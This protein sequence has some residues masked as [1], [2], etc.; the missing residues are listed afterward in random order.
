MSTRPNSIY[1]HQNNY[2]VL[3]TSHDSLEVILY[4]DNEEDH[5]SFHPQ[6]SPPPQQQSNS[7]IY[8]DIVHEPA[9][10]GNEE[11][12]REVGEEDDIFRMDDIPNDLSAS[13]ASLGYSWSS[14]ASDDSTST[15]KLSTSPSTS[16]LHEPIDVPSS[17]IQ[18]RYYVPTNQEPQGLS[19]SAVAT[20][21]DHHYI[22]RHLDYHQR[23]SL[24]QSTSY[25]ID[26]SE[27]V[28]NCDSFDN[29]EDVVNAIINSDNIS[30]YVPFPSSWSATGGCI[31]NIYS[32]SAPNV[33]YLTDDLLYSYSPATTEITAPSQ[34]DSSSENQKCNSNDECSN[35]N[36]S[37]YIEAVHIL[38]EEVEETEHLSQPSIIIKAEELDIFSFNDREEA[39]EACLKADPVVSAVGEKEKYA[40]DQ[41]NNAHSES[42]EQYHE[43]GGAVAAETINFSLLPKEGNKEVSGYAT[44]GEAV[45]ETNILNKMQTQVSSSTQHTNLR[46]KTLTK[47]PIAGVANESQIKPDE[48]NPTKE[49][50]T[51]GDDNES[52]SL[53]ADASYGPLPEFQ[54]QKQLSEEESR[55]EK[56]Y[57]Q[58]ELLKKLKQNTFILRLLNKYSCPLKVSNLP[59]TIRYKRLLDHFFDPSVLVC[60]YM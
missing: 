33:S 39:K 49:V 16:F 41:I 50:D 9:F 28:I 37:S 6:Q 3:G 40:I 45:L 26:D 42:V 14:N 7:S 30:Q 38:C 51:N 44:E 5:R 17:P 22:R 60:I 52:W 4:S 35:T 8:N 1:C 31:P 29:E 11:L 57:Q 2:S 18:V 34:L 25:K 19:Q 43:G 21:V 59:Y 53:L 12:R 10:I 32:Q 24:L 54:F 23:R 15:A 36:A 27:Q 20:T 48:S 47:T 55:W 56:L 13:I 58:S 46:N